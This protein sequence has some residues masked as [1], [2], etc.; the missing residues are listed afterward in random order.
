MR[1]FST[2]SLFPGTSVLLTRARYL[3]MIPWLLQ[4]T[5]ATN[6]DPTAGLAHLRQLEGCTQ[7]TTATGS[8][9]T[10]PARP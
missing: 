9:G 7:P 4:D 8:S 10:C 5:C 6:K 3:V 1:D 2:D